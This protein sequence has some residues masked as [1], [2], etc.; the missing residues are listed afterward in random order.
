MGS[1]QFECRNCGNKEAFSV[2]SE[3]EVKVVFEKKT[4]KTRRTKQ[5]YTVGTCGVCSRTAADIQEINARDKKKPFNYTT[6]PVE[7]FIHQGKFIRGIVSSQNG[8]KYV[9]DIVTGNVIRKEKCFKVESNY[10]NLIPS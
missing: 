9:E 3:T 1:K 4:G 7:K 6:R 2:R 8:T 5:R 10:Q